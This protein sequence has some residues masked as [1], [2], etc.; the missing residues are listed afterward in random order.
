MKKVSV[1]FRFLTDD[2]RLG[3]SPGDMVL[4]GKAVATM[5]LKKSSALAD[6]DVDSLNAAGIEVSNRTLSTARAA[7]DKHKFIC[8]LV[9]NHYALLVAADKDSVFVHAKR[10]LSNLRDEQWETP[11]H[12][13]EV[14]E[15][16]V[17]VLPGR[18]RVAIE[19]NHD[20][21]WTFFETA[22][23]TDTDE[24]RQIEGVMCDPVN[25][26]E[27]SSDVWPYIQGMNFAYAYMLKF[28]GD[29][30][31]V[32]KT[33]K[34][35][36]RLDSPGLVM[37]LG[38]P[39]FGGGG[40]DFRLFAQFSKVCLS[41]FIDTARLSQS[42]IFEDFILSMMSAQSVE[43]AYWK[44]VTKTMSAMETLSAM[45]THYREDEE[46]SPIWSWHH[47]APERALAYDVQVDRTKRIRIDDVK[48]VT[49]EKCAKQLELDIPRTVLT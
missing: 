15:G 46:R 44:T 20:A 14:R 28:Y 30:D 17:H 5:V 4:V 3:D 25:N 23:A 6:G 45:E 49:A 35:L 38:V 40:D 19:G 48:H 42:A 9:V 1:S 34:Q 7:A 2:Q 33:V 21:V 13:F 11:V 36:S 27:G 12:Y 10:L 26:A 8:P 43:Y 39:A 47:D 37:E 41:Y 31:F 18:P 29:T 22:K 24:Y 32:A 16:D